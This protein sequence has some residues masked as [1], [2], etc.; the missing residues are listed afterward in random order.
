ML[1]K[2]SYGQ[3]IREDKSTLSIPKCPFCTRAFERPEVIKGDVTDFIGGSCDCGA[4]YIY[5]DSEKNLGETLL[6]ALVFACNG[7]WDKAMMLDCDEDYNEAVIEYG[8]DS[9]SVPVVSRT[10]G[11]GVLLFLRLKV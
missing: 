4:V 1:K 6:D 9:H 10:H 2:K 5:D 11:K 7:D 8:Y 3:K